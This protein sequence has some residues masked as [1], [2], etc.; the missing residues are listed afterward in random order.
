MVKIDKSSR[1]LLE[2]FSGKRKRNTVITDDLIEFTGQMHAL[3]KA[4]FMISNAMTFLQK[5]IPSKP[6]EDALFG[7]ALM[8]E[9]GSSLT[10]GL[11]EYPNVFPEYYRRSIQAAETG[12]TLRKTFARLSRYL[13]S[14]KKLEQEIK[15]RF[16]YPNF[17]LK[18]IIAGGLLLAFWQ[19]KLAF[20]S[21]NFALILA[22][23]ISYYFIKDLL[24]VY[25]T[26]RGGKK[27]W[28]GIRLDAPLFGGAYRRSLNRQFAE[29]FIS[30][31][32]TG[33]PIT[34]VFTL[35][36]E[37][38]DNKIFGRAVSSI[39]ETIQNGSTIVD[40]VDQ[41]IYFPHSLKEHF[42]TGAMTGEYDKNLDSFI[43]QEDI[44]IRD[45]ANKAFLYMY[46]LYLIILIALI[47]LM[48]GSFTR[49]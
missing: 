7:I 26:K 3:Y 33:L 31:Y 24:I 17:V 1:L 45:F 36:G 49:Y 12:G 44:R 25:L 42:H 27:Y 6:M 13:K 43:Q 41:C 28:D 47:G 34:D 29:H 39:G 4:G 2:A 9:R 48:R 20:T 30:M 40:A 21:S 19:K 14:R 23:I 38:I 37:A 46:L 11:D 18:S 8:L 10:K 35:I 32:R 15:K 16:F 5:E 22:A